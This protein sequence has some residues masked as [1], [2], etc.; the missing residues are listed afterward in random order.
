M[1]DRPGDSSVA[2]DPFSAMG[3]HHMT[4]AGKPVLDVP[5]ALVFVY[6]TRQFL[7]E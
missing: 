1:R 7:P 6:S 2:P 3:G 4:L 5:S